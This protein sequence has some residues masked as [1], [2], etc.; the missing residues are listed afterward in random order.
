M[1]SCLAVKFRFLASEREDLIDRNKCI[2]HTAGA[3]AANFDSTVL[4]PGD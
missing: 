2:G 4:P 3:E 1:L